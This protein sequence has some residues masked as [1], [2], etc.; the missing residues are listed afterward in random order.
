M[1]VIDTRGHE[2]FSNLRSR[3]SSMCDF[4]ILVVDILHALEKQTLESIELLRART[5]F[6]IALNKI[7]RIYQWKSKKE[8]FSHFKLEDQSPAT[9]TEFK[10]RLNHIIVKFAE[11]GMNARLFYENPNERK[12]INIIPT[13]AITEGLSDLICEILDLSSKYMKNKIT[14]H[15]KMLATALEVKNVEG[16]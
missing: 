1:L 16:V 7:D 10:E 15:E 8:G 11:M 2:T 9:I 5:P 4:A 3:G 6:L 14:Y 13:S 12:F